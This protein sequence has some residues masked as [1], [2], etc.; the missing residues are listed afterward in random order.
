V[1]RRDIDN[2]LELA[3]AYHEQGLQLIP[4]PAG[5]KAANKKWKHR[6]ERPQTAGD[7]REMF[8]HQAVN[9]AI[10]S[11]PESGNFCTIDIDEPRLYSWACQN[12]RHFTDLVTRTLACKSGGRGGVHI[13]IKTEHPLTNTHFQNPQDPAKK[14]GDIIAAGGYALYPRSM[15]RGG[16]YQL[17]FDGFGGIVDLDIH[18]RTLKDLIH[19]FNLREHVEPEPLPTRDTTS[20]IIY[21]NGKPYGLSLK[22]WNLLTQGDTA[23]RYATRSEADQAVIVSCVLRGWDLETVR[24]LFRRHSY[25]GGKYREKE[26]HRDKYLAICYRN[27]EKYLSQNKAEID[28]NIDRLTDLV[29][30]WPWKGQ[31]GRTDKDISLALLEIARRRRSLEGFGASIRELGELAGTSYKTAHRALQRNPFIIDSTTDGITCT[32]TVKVP[33]NTPC[34]KSVSVLQS[35]NTTRADVFR[36]GGLGKA[37]ADIYAALLQYGESDIMTLSQRA[38]VAF[39]TVYNKINDLERAGLVTVRKQGRQTLLQAVQG[40]DLD[41]A[42]RIVGTAGALK[43][44]IERHERERTAYRSYIKRIQH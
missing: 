22:A 23:G 11:G 19:V 10:Y 38:R 36:W 40:A 21:K 4:L 42:A 14:G 37:G 2:Q 24:E 26:R 17:L 28:T 1:N 43:R 15:V 12:V 41:R 35:G 7:V 34:V 31:G 16:A 5:V 33:N 29:H 25:Q 27:A 8:G 32:F 44:Q 9:T 30:N 13:G 20:G 3:L 6:L 18:D 39:R